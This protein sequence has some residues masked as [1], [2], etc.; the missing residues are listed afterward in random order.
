MIGTYQM[1]KW[2]ME[3]SVNYYSGY[4]VQFNDLTYTYVH[5]DNTPG[6]WD[7]ADADIAISGTNVVVR[8][9]APNANQV[10]WRCQLEVSE[11]G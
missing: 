2:V 6:A 3:A 1:C 9:T 8:V 5:R 10:E 4:P 7:G 11:H